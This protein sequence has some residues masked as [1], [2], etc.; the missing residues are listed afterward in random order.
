[1]VIVNGVLQVHA[2]SRDSLS[3]AGSGGEHDRLK[4]RLTAIALTTP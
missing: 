4:E 1:M 2:N 3:C